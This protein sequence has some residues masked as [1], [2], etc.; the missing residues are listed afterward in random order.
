L[1]NW[2]QLAERSSAI[3]QTSSR[4]QASLSQ[5]KK[6][7]KHL[8]LGLLAE[9]EN[10]NDASVALERTSLAFHSQRRRTSFSLDKKGA[11]APTEALGQLLQE[12]C[13]ALRDLHLLQNCTIYREAGE[14]SSIW[15]ILA[16][17]K[18]KFLCY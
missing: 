6:N 4:R 12:T 15:N 16:L 8:Q 14:G 18:L 11:S 17:G 9:L 13:D 2:Q 3:E 10:L 1:R 7:N 5:L